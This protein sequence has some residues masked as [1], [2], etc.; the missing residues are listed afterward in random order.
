MQPKALVYKICRKSFLSLWSYVNPKQKPYGRELCDILVLCNPDII[1]VSVKHSALPKNGTPEVNVARW[2]RR[3]ID[4]SV[5]QIYGA[6]RPLKHLTHVIKSDSSLGVILPNPTEARVHPGAI[7]LGSEGALGMPY[8][9]FGKGF[10]HVLDE[11]AAEILLQ[12]L[13]TIS[14]FVKSR[15][16]NVSLFSTFPKH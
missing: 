7:A 4:A 13:D 10:V 5:S 16:P 15:S 11:S 8:E 6:E 1:I 9:D 14:D 3:A 12:E 2:K